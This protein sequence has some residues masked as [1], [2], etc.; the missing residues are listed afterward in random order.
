ML[1]NENYKLYWDRTIITDK[2][3]YN[4]RPDITMLDKRNKLVY[5]IDIAICNTH[6]LV[7]THSEKIA[8]YTDLSIELKT[9]WNV[10]Q[11]KTIPIILSTT[12]VIPKSLH[13]SLSTLHISPSTY[14]LLQKAVI[15]NTCR[16]TRKFL[17]S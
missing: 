1:E 6:N 5:I 12:G 16:L 7:N 8:K 17:N 2:T 9:Q 10:T 15:L 11:T 14:L 3:I 13:N 4:N